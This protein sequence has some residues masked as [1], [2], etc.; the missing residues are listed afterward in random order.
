M[1]FSA[2]DLADL[3][4]SGFNNHAGRRQILLE[5]FGET[6]SPP[7]GDCDVCR[8]RKEKTATI[9]GSPSSEEKVLQALTGGSCTWDELEAKTELDRESLLETVNLVE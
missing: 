6:G 8:I 4:A 3:S 9:A 2:I 7:C 1:K 5:Y